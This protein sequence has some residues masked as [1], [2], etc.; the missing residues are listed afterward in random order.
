VGAENIVSIGVHHCQ[1]EKFV[2]NDFLQGM[3]KGIVQDKDVA[4]YK[5]GACIGC[6]TYFGDGFP[7][8][9]FCVSE[10]VFLLRSTGVQLVQNALYLWLNESSTISAIRTANAN[11]AQPCINLK[12][13]KGLVAVTPSGETVSR[14]DEMVEPYRAPIVSFVK[15][16][17]MLH[18][19]RDLLL[20]KLISGELD[21]SEPD[22]EIREAA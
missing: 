21:V 11:A 13:V 14:F 10:H 22:I 18:Q 17:N 12:G 3:R 6:S 1:N 15:R 19:T 4:L 8:A 2:S 16:N 9:D 7:H 5:G 20:P